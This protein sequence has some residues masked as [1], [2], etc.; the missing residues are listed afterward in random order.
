MS[1]LIRDNPRFAVLAFPAVYG[2]SGVMSFIVNHGAVVYQ[3]DLGPDTLTEVEKITT[4]D[5][6]E[7]WQAVPETDLVVIPEEGDW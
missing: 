7:S 6:G 1:D 2:E 4:Y 3:R 5:P